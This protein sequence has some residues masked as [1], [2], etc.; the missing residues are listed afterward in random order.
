MY[1]KIEVYEALNSHTS[2][3]PWKGLWTGK[4]E[5]QKLVMI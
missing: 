1:R 5:G 4:L 3:Q 2:K